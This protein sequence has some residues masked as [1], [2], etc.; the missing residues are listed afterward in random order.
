M[1]I[2]E[3]IE[4][5]NQKQKEKGNVKRF[6]RKDLHYIPKEEALERVKECG[7]DLQFVQ[8]QNEEICLEAIKDCPFALCYVKDQTEE[9]CLE[10]VKGSSTQLISVRQQTIEMC[11]EAINENPYMVAFIDVSLFEE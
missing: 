11:I 10:A 2:D 7:L 8:H 4:Y 3:I 6:S 9:I 5:A 1:K